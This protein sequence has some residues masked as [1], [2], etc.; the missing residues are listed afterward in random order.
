[1]LSASSSLSSTKRIDAMRKHS[2]IADK[3]ARTTGCRG[4]PHHETRLGTSTFLL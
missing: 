2:D 3:Q 4:T 1:M